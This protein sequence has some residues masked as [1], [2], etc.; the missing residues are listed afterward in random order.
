M[1]EW[2][3]VYQLGLTLFEA[4]ARRPMYDE[5]EYRVRLQRMPKEQVKD[6]DPRRLILEEVQDLGRLHPH[7]PRDFDPTLPD[8]LEKLIMTSCQKHVLERYT[9]ELALEHAEDLLKNKVF[10]HAEPDRPPSDERKRESRTTLILS[11]SEALLAKHAYAEA[12]AYE[13]CLSLLGQA[14]HETDVIA[15]ADFVEKAAGSL[16]RLPRAKFTL[17]HARHESLVKGLEA[18][19]DDIEAFRPNRKIALEIAEGYD[20][21]LGVVESET[22]FE[23]PVSELRKKGEALRAR[24]GQHLERIRRTGLPERITGKYLAQLESILQ[25]LPKM[26][27]TLAARK[28]EFIRKK[29]EE[30]DAAIERNPNEAALI[31]LTLKRALESGEPDDLSRALLAEIQRD[32]VPRLKLEG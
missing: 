2:T 23:T 19:R 13:E 7:F 11:A 20:G 24:A 29:K 8:E 16:A 25:E 31:V 12:E 21:L 22:F 3:D 26:E 27:E 15:L 30:L 28:G 17:L 6:P 18:E 5:N 9:C 32:Y 14:E 1:G 10:A 4:V